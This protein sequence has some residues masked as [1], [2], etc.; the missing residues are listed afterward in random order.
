MRRLFTLLRVQRGFVRECCAASD[1]T[2]QRLASMRSCPDK[3]EGAGGTTQDG[4]PS[5]TFTR[6]RITCIVGFHSPIH[7]STG[8]YG[9]ITRKCI[10]SEKYTNRICDRADPRSDQ[11]NSAFFTPDRHGCL[12]NALYTFIEKLLRLP[13]AIGQARA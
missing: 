2:R 8:L 11:R 12:Q 6:K 3:R 13:G 10:Q 7:L 1:V 5:V 9:S 4:R